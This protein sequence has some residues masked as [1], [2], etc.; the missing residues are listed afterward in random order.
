MKKKLTRIA[1]LMLAAVMFAGTS[2]STYAMDRSYT[3]NYDWWGD[4][5][6]SPDFYTVCKV[7]TYK[8][9]GLDTNMKTPDSLFAIDDRLFICDT[10]NNR[11]I[12]LKRGE[13]E[14][15]ELVRYIYGFKP[16][17]DSE[18]VTTFAN[19][20]DIAVS[21]DG[22]IFVADYGNNRIV[23]MDE[24]LNYIMQFN[25]PVDASLDPNTPFKP[26]K[27]VIDTAERVYCVA[28]GINKGLV[29][30]ENDGVFSGF[31]GAN[32]VT[33]NWVDY[34]WKKFSTQAQRDKMESFVP[35][36]YDNAYIDKDGFIYVCTDGYT[37]EEW[38]AETAEAVRKLNM[39]GNDILVRNG[40][41][42]IYGDLYTGAA[43][44][45]SGPS[46]FLDVTVLDN[47]VYVCLDSNRGRLFGYDDQGKLVF[48]FG[49]GGPKEGYFR[50]Q[51]SPTAVEHMGNEL[52]VLDNLDCSI[53]M[54][55]TTEFGDAVYEAMEEFD[56]GNYEASEA[57]WRHAMSLN[58]NYDLAYIGI[59]RALLR[60]ERY[61][62]AMEYFELKYDAE[63]YSKAYQQ[64]RKIWVEENI[65][66]IAIVLLIL[67]LIP[68]GIGKVK[69]IKHEIDT[70]DIFRF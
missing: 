47:D 50:K 28:E 48:A 7:F 63:N 53:T 25:A 35:T 5:Q 66:T 13:N 27:I 17:D 46:A 41:Y 59:G 20:K 15:F 44:Q 23:K 1:A 33:F 56:V 4:V 22:D 11:I 12:E 32:K 36:E 18:T 34:L 26:K 52:Y 8:D 42:P 16:V 69:K 2:I 45:Y 30:Y 37:E 43:G 29:K 10:G 38:T 6:D 14:T 70:A 55:V 65:G 49:G 24:N 39:M 21:K 9:L 62:E 58:G 19:P 68:L 64:Y 60:Q 54:F 61:G 31:I 57:A 67:I 40:T 51:Y 3:Y